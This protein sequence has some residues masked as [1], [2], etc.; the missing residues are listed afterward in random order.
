VA[1]TSPLTGPGGHAIEDADRRE[2]LDVLHAAGI[3]E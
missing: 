3:N 2:R 1:T